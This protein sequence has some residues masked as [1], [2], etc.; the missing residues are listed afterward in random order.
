VLIFSPLTE[1][2]NVPNSLLYIPTPSVR[3]STETLP[4]SL[5]TSITR[6]A[7]SETTIFSIC[8]SK[9]AT[10]ELNSAVLRTAPA[11]SPIFPS[12][13]FLPAT[14]IVLYLEPEGVKI[15]HHGL[16]LVLNSCLTSSIS[17]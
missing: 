11:S 13:A 2:N 17:F 4:V 12:Y 8:L 7:F 3:I 14:L 6:F 15:S 16:S 5:G 9:S 1:L 10:L